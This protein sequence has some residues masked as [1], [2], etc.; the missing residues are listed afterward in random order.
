MMNSRRLIGSPSARDG[1]RSHSDWWVKAI[2]LKGNVA[3]GSFASRTQF[4]YVQFALIATF[5]GAAV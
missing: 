1:Y 2:R 4:S 3:C 5:F